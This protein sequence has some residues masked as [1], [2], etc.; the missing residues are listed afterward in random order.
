MKKINLTGLKLH[1]FKGVRDFELCT[2]A[3]HVNVFGANATGKTTLFDAFT[4]LL[5]G[6]NSEDAKKFN[7]KPL[8]ES[9]EELLGLE[10]DV[11]ATFLV[12]GK[13]VTLHRILKEN[14][15]KPK[16]QLEKQRKPDTTSL[17]V[18]EVPKKVKEYQ[19]FISKIIDED[20]FK[21]L[22]NP[23]QFVSQ[24]WTKQREVLT[25][26][27]GTMSDEEVIKSNSALADLIKLLNGHSVEDQKKVVASQKRKI[28]KDIE[29]IPAR[30]DEAERAKPET[31]STSK[32][33]LI[34][35]NET[36]Q[37]SLDKAQDTL[38]FA[39]NSAGTVEL[40][41]KKREL[42]SDL[43]NEKAKFDAGSQMQLSGLMNDLNEQQSLLSNTNSDLYNAK[44]DVRDIENEV[45]MIDSKINS[46]SELKRQLLDIYHSE[47]EVVFDES[48]T[49]CVTCGQDLPA[50]KVDE[51]RTHFN[52]EHSKKLEEIIAK[53]K[54]QA[55][56]I[57]ELE[58]NKGELN[59]KLVEAKT[60]LDQLVDK[61]AKE[62]EQVEKLK[63]EINLQ[64]EQTPKFED[65][66][67]FSEIK[68][69]IADI[70]LKLTNAVA[71]NSQAIN[72]AQ[73]KIDE[74]KRNMNQI[75]T[76]ISKY[77][78]I[79]T[80]DA[81]IT[82][83]KEE[84]TKLKQKFNELDKT[85]YLIDQFNRT[86]INLLESKINDHFELVSFK[87]F[88]LQK[89]GEINETCEALVDGVPY[90]DLNNAARINAGLD[91]INTLINHFEV[92]APIFI[93]NAE[94]VNNILDTKAQQI[95]LVVT[96]DKKLKVSEA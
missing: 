67:K 87:L 64:K 59:T 26:I 19:D 8:D 18:N 35:M 36:Y 9:S 65:S 96:E 58:A 38:N 2:N 20:T 49:V 43:L 92:S 6:K 83:L 89:N 13:K 72:E 82:E 17:Y 4:W 95:A 57:D 93:D 55:S 84:E 33:T 90:S 80:Q 66:K 50:N 73:A 27:A 75:N 12:D 23:T 40:Q 1:N 45:S 85:D 11:E 44:G 28:K 68:Q 94:S 15:V 46:T 63:Q 56:E 34:K 22:T 60:M 86:K 52:L 69:E 14:W 53:G 41:L 16:G 37:E 77:E 61:Q 10:P 7:V 24:H 25:E 51:I 88:D 30:I 32:E 54:E 71:E 21:M 47:K 31:I 3:E 74:I 5:F 62:L 70:D 29:G 42:N 39:K 81:R 91:I 78:Q 76:E 79:E 48:A